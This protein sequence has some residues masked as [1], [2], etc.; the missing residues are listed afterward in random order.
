MEIGSALLIRPSWSRRTPRK[1]QS[2]VVLDPGL[3]FGTGQHPTTAFCL[4]Q[5]V[6]RRN[7]DQPQSLL[8]LGCGSGILA[9]AAAKL[10]YGPVEAVE[11]DAEALQIA[12]ANA[13]RN[14]VSRAIRFMQ[15]DVSRL[16]MRG[17]P[18]YS[19]V[20]ANLTSDL[21]M[22]Q[23]RRIL[24]R[25]RHDGALVLAGILKE[26]FQKVQTRYQAAGL[27]LIRRRTEKEWR[28]GV[29]IFQKI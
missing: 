27:R 1:G 21:L 13:R 9:I 11:F 19:V 5:V 18:K 6:K 26:E 28:S 29:F 16:P 14:G 17:A 12:R 22:D 7:R 20:C 15:Q 24:T 25:L 10:G 3:S 23:A 8:D 2:Q 4:Q